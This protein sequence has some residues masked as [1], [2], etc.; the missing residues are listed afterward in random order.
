[1]IALAEDQG[2]QPHAGATLFPAEGRMPPSQSRPVSTAQA[3]D[4]LDAQIAWCATGNRAGHRR[5]PMRALLGRVV[6]LR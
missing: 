2:S 5:A 6:V 4:T 3:I 1:M